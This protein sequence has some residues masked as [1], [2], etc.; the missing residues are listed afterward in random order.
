MYAMYPQYSLM[1]SSL[2]RPP[3]YLPANNRHQTTRRSKVTKISNSNEFYISFTQDYMK[4]STDVVLEDANFSNF[5]G[6]ISS[7]PQKITK[8]EPT[9]YQKVDEFQHRTFYR[10]KIADSSYHKANPNSA[11]ENF[12]WKVRSAPTFEQNVTY[13]LRD[14]DVVEVISI[15]DNWLQLKTGWTLYKS[16]NSEEIMFEEIT[17]WANEWKEI[18]AIFPRSHERVQDVLKTSHTANS[19]LD[20]MIKVASIALKEFNCSIFG[21]FVRDFVFKN[22]EPSDLDLRIPTSEFQPF[23]SDFSHFVRQYGMIMTC[24]K[25]S[26]CLTKAQITDYTYEVEIDF[27]LADGFSGGETVDFDVNNFQVSVFGQD[28]KPI[29]FQRSSI[30]KSNIAVLSNISTK[31][32]F[33]Q[34]QHNLIYKQYREFLHLHRVKKMKEKG[35]NVKNENLL[36][37]KLNATNSNLSLCDT[38]CNNYSI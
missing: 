13:C 27:V 8:N 4:R 12:C 25:S 3:M 29:V 21:G 38:A 28:K 30:G 2:Y 31:I 20:L 14:G 15:K 9:E 19:K 22:E 11:I 23:L 26:K 24:E 7:F 37:T 35:W 6:K 32:C 5:F 16:Q 36:C 33:I 18:D 34:S 17:E 10:L 1:P